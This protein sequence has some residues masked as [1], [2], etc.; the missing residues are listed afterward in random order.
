MTRR[1]G[2][3][4]IDELVD[5]GECPCGVCSNPN[6]NHEKHICP[7]CYQEVTGFR[8]KKSERE[9]GISGL[10]QQCQDKTFNKKKAVF[11]KRLATVLLVQSKLL[12]PSVLGVK[13]LKDKI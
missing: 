9:F 4:T 10:C 8:D 6:D 1:Q 7:S 13:D 3:L 11:T 5:S 2:R 12:P